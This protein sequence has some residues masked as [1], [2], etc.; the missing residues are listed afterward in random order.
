M[1]KNAKKFLLANLENFSPKTKAAV[2]LILADLEKAEKKISELENNAVENLPDEIWKD[3]VGYEGIYKISNFGR[4]KSFK[5][6]KVVILKKVLNDGY[7]SIGLRKDGKRFKAKIHRLI[8][9]AFIPNPDNKPFVNHIDGNKQN[10][11]IENL[12]WVTGS[13]NVRHAWQIGLNKSQKGSKHHNAKLTDE[14]V[15]FIR[16]NYNPNDS[17]FSARKLAKKFG[18]IHSTILNV[19][20]KKTYLSVE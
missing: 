11:C 2:K 19:L 18:V 3:V 13:E 12:E 4:V 7:Y 1:S 5:Q 6:N 15:K 8:A 10:N 9:Q 16:E 14:D 20:H 17:E